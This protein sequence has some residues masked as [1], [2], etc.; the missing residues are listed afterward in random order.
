[1]LGMHYIATATK[2]TANHSVRVYLSAPTEG[3]GWDHRKAMAECFISEDDAKIVA[4]AHVY[5][6][7]T[8][9]VEIS[10]VRILPLYI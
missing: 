2:R 6:C 4:M 3:R 10:E 8:S 5:G 9:F 1:M 7:C